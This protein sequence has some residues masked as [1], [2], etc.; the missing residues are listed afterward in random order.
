MASCVALS[1]L[2]E[3]IIFKVQLECFKKDAR[4]C[5]YHDLIVELLIFCFM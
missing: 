2:L 5:H 3:M 4:L 1:V